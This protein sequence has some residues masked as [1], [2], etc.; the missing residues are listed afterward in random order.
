MIQMSLI[1]PLQKDKKRKSLPTKNELPSVKENFYSQQ[2][3]PTTYI[4]TTAMEHGDRRQ[5]L[6]AT[7]DGRTHK[8]TRLPFTD[9]KT[10][11]TAAATSSHGSNSRSNPPALQQLNETTTTA[12][13]SGTATTQNPPAGTAT[14]TRPTTRKA[15]AVAHAPFSSTSHNTSIYDF[16]NPKGSSTAATTKATAAAV[17]PQKR[18]SS[19]SLSA[20]SLSSSAKKT[21]ASLRTPPK[22]AVPSA[23][24]SRVKP[25]PPSPPQPS[26]GLDKLRQRCQELE[27]LCQDR[28][29]QLAA[30]SNNRTIIHTALQQALSK[31][32]KE[33]IN[34]KEEQHALQSNS[35]RVLEDLSR[36][37]A[38]REARELRE[39]LAT[40]GARL[41]RIVYTR[42][43][44]RSVETWEDGRA[45]KELLKRKTAL[46]EKRLTLEKRQTAAKRVIK[47]VEESKEN[48]SD[49]SESS[50][51]DEVEL[52]G[53]IHVRTPLEVMEASES[54]RFHLSN[55]RRQEKELVLEDQTLNDEKCA[56]IRAL[57]RVASEDS[58][59][60]RSRPKV[61]YV[62]FFY[63]MTQ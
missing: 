32:Q 10:M 14:T 13:A 37:D 61:R 34:L 58:S 54:V 45:S 57:K 33:L 8:R 25:P 9:K 21:A 16:F 3:P 49:V 29:E 51:P 59:R 63:G 24:A 47:Q 43:G 1:S 20:S 22:Q 55:V 15:G 56:H 26:P 40:D 35:R 62:G 27:R 50:D 6:S 2:L 18:R 48:Q 7:A 12:T 42:A 46:Q 52:V 28:D 39:R 60:F 44:M 4:T 31:T 23:A 36:S 11:V 53:G 5:L 30:V 17:S 41:G 19:S 38:A